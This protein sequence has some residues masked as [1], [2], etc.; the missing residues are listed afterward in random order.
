MRESAYQERMWTRRRGFKNYET[1]RT[2]C[3]YAPP[4]LRLSKTWGGL[5]PGEGAEVPKSHYH[6]IYFSGISLHL[7]PGGNFVEQLWRHIRHALP[8]PTSNMTA[9]RRVSSLPPSIIVAVGGDSSVGA[10]CRTDRERLS[11]SNNTN[12]DEPNL[13]KNKAK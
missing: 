12:L 2:S 6:S 13:S 4:S 5:S 11:E 8:S 3:A 1:S 10:A 7:P 9:S